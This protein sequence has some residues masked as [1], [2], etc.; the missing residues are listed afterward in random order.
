MVC[1][2]TGG[3]IR[4]VSEELAPIVGRREALS[5]FGLVALA[6][7]CGSSGQR[8]GTSASSS[9]TTRA[10]GSVA[11]PAPTSAAALSTTTSTT[12]VRGHNAALDHEILALD[13]RG[14]N[15]RWRGAWSLGGGGSGEISGNVTIDPDARTLVAVI[16]PGIAVLGGAPLPGFTVR[17]SV[18]SF[19]YDGQTGEFHIR[20]TTPVGVAALDSV[21][22]MGSGTFKLTVTNIPA[23]LDVRSVVATGRANQGGVIPTEFTILR[24]DGTAQ[25]GSVTFS[26]P[27]RD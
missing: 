9:V 22:G 23:H 4:D 13:A 19:V 24:T 6:A 12:V 2:V 20:Q 18:D 21:R 11:P 15:G 14:F 10:P 16:D 3:R 1:A 26:Q 5:L 27:G 25:H 8:G 17:G 7:A